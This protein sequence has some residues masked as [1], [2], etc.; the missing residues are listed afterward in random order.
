[1]EEII[2]NNH[3]WRI[4]HLLKHSQLA[5]F[6]F[7]SFIASLLFFLMFAGITYS[8]TQQNFYS[9][10]IDIHKQLQEASEKYV[11]QQNKAPE[12]FSDF[13]TTSGQPDGKLTFSLEDKRLYITKITPLDSNKLSILFKDKGMAIYTLTG[14]DV[15]ASFRGFG[16]TT[17]P[18][19]DK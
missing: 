16:Q 14:K 11:S 3:L 10:A 5:Q 15:V 1:M 19:Q 12:L 8:Q 2:L 4:F 13:I 7:I 6:V 17:I 18:Q 9:L